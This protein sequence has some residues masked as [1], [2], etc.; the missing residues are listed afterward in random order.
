MAS[1]MP[2][3]ALPSGF[4]MARSFERDRLGTVVSYPGVSEG[5]LAPM[6]GLTIVMVPT[7]QGTQA[8][9]NAL[10]PDVPSAISDET[11]CS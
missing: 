7:G 4:R 1:F 9:A 3:V 6:L 2:R 8:V 10:V 11:Q 5:R